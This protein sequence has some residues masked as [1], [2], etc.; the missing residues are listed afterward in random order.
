MTEP[1]HTLEAITE[2]LKGVAHLPITDD[3]PDT[4]QHYGYRLGVGNNTLGTLWHCTDDR[5]HPAHAEYIQNG[6][7]TADLYCNSH[8]ASIDDEAA[9]A[10]LNNARQDIQA[11]LA[12]LGVQVELQGED[13]DA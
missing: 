8:Y 7:D 6:W 13:E 4:S 10:F 5:R 1:E 11:L 12:M 9:F 2:R 3:T